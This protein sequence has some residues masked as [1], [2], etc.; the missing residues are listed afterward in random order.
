MS[1]AQVQ[2]QKQK[3]PIHCR[4][5]DQE[6]KFHKDHRGPQGGWIP[7]NPDM[8]VHNCANKA[9]GQAQQLAMDPQNT[10]F[11]PST[12]D[13]NNAVDGIVQQIAQIRAELRVNFEQISR[14][15]DVIQAEVSK[16]Q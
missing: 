2:P 3:T 15:L 6:I 16:R 5:C 8:T 11:T 4:G 12:N 13:A 7:M 10:A 14:R 1:Q 9:K